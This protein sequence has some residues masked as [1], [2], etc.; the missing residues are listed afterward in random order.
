MKRII[1]AISLIA[2]V[3]TSCSTNSGK[4]L[5]TD[6]TYRKLVHD[7][8]LK[9]KEIAHGRDSIL[10]SVFDQQLP[11]AEKEGLEFLYAFMP[12]SDLAMNDGEYNLAQVR[13]A[14][15]AKAFFN[16]GGKIPDEI[17]LHF[18]LPY[19]VN[20]EYTDTARQVFFRELKE[21]IKD[22]GMA[23]AALEVNHWC[24]E[25]V[26]YKSTDERTSGPLTSVRTAFG[27]C[28][29][30]STFTAAAMRS[31]CIP[32]RQVYTPRW[33][34]TDDN[35]AWVEVW[36]DGKWQFMGACEPEPA[37]DMGWFA[38]PVKRAMMTHTFV[39]GRYEGTEEVLENNDLFARLNLLGNYTDTK[40]LPVKVKG[41]DGKPVEKAR[42]DY[43]LYNYAEFYPIATLYTD[44]NG[45]CTAT[46]GYGDLMMWASKDGRFSYKVAPG[47]S[48]DTV[49][50]TLQA[51]GYNLP[52]EI[53]TLTP[54]VKKALPPA[55]QSKSEANNRRLQQEDSIRNAY[56]AT[57]IDSVFAV[58][59]AFDKGVDAPALWNHLSR[60]RGNWKEITAFIKGLNTDDLTNGMA[61]LANISEKDL[62]DIQ[63]STLN[64]HLKALANYPAFTEEGAGENFERYVLSPR[65]GREFVT[66]WRSYIQQSFSREQAAAFR[67]DP[68]EIRTWISKSI[69]LDTV[70]NYYGVPLNPEGM[71]QLGRADRYSR[72]L[73][74]VAVARSFGIPARL[75]PATR[76]PQFLSGINWSDVFFD[77]HT[78]KTIPQG[79][80]ILE[81]LSDD[82]SFVPRYYT[83]FTIA[84]FDRGRFVTLDYEYDESLNV[85]PCKLSVDTGY[86]R[87]ITGN[88]MSDGSVL[89]SI[90]YFRVRSEKPAM[91]GIRMVSQPKE[92]GIL[93]KADLLAGFLN[94]KAQKQSSLKEFSNEKGMVIA[95]IDP[96]K[97]PTKHLMED[98]RAVKTSLEEWG[99]RMLF[100]V[101]QDKLSPGFSPAV[102][103]GLP[104]DVI[105]GHDAKGEVS[106]SVTTVC[107]IG[108]SPNWPVVALVN[109]KGE[110][111]WHSEGYSIGLGDQLVK[112]IR[113]LER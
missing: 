61:L 96:G 5:I 15:E 20:N 90:S 94:L 93:G 58:E 2:I 71:L 53:L 56:I 23:E 38:E 13:S 98:V 29:E 111:I 43:S 80:I 99:G 88:R 68:M 91:I 7:Q 72:D 39:F 19:R 81:N 4:H 85:F 49:V 45:L 69:A 59:L 74:F 113:D 55:D 73:L 1:Y 25:K 41:A 24:H 11:T 60:S 105:F 75:E 63:A 22:M 12:L 109:G 10:F 27:R 104:S 18:V 67:D 34:H 26:S 102:Y 66:K 16:W 21:R 42:V 57:F 108:N 97:E 95:L 103:K 64:D 89:C 82:K 100:I 65:I 32:A 46:T 44:I 110:I 78:E 40:T 3:L 83:H 35:H 9:Q 28:G 14:L 47:A 48:S 77:K 86:Y 30:E 33:A 62:H 17:F 87:L 54:P 84:R 36:V 8:F 6:K 101:A 51:I 52:S 107:S 37:L 31:V 76:R 106:A 70:N 50:L 79:Q 112:R 92:S